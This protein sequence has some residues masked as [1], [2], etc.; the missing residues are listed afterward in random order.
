M[1]KIYKKKRKRSYKPYRRSSVKRKTPYHRRRRFGVTKK[2]YYKRRAPKSTLSLYK[3]TVQPRLPYNFPL[4]WRQRLD[5][6][7]NNMGNNDA[8]YVSTTTNSSLFMVFRGNSPYDPWYPTDS[9]TDSARWYNLMVSLYKQE[10]VRS[11][12]IFIKLR[13]LFPVSGNRYSNYWRIYLYPTLYA[14]V[15][16]TSSGFTHNFLMA[17][18]GVSYVDMSPID[19]IHN[20]KTLKGFV[21]VAQVGAFENAAMYGSS[22]FWNNTGQNPST[23]QSIYWVLVALPLKQN[24]PSLDTASAKD[25]FL[26]DVKMRMYCDFRTPQVIAGQITDDNILGTDNLGSGEAAITVTGNIS[27]IPGTSGQS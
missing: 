1:P 9:T 11:S 4:R 24:T 8:W 19:G 14:G 3:R 20:F 27:D 15:P 25:S 18:P 6:R 12:A 7:F 2:R 22:A 13:S 26:V 23:G 16:G 21:D 10:R 5:W 17:L